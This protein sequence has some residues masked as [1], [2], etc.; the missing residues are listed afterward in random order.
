MDDIAA[1]RVIDLIKIDTDGYELEV[2]KGA[3]QTNLRNTPAIYR[4]FA[5]RNIRFHGNA[6][7][8]RL[9]A[10]LRELGYA[11]VLAYAN[12]GSTIGR[13]AINGEVMTALTQ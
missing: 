9:L 13:Y 8:H 6:S 12:L 5:P 10:D 3:R 7:P 1:D 4:E 11:S 2:I